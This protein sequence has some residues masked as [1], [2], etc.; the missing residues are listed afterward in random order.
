[1]YYAHSNEITF[2]VSK[3]NN[4]GGLKSGEKNF[5]W[6]K[7]AYLAEVSFYKKKFEKFLNLWNFSSIAN[8]LEYCF[9][10]L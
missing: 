1:M 5:F 2:C 8:P 10:L 4:Q 3:T 7:E 6:Q 9:Y